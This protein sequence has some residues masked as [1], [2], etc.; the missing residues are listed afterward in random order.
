MRLCDWLFRAILRDCQVL[1]YAVA[2]F[3]L[4]PIERRIYEVARATCEEDGLDLD[5]TTFR[6]QIGY[7]NPLANFKAALR[8]IVATNT[9]PDY[10][11]EL[12]EMTGGGPADVEP[13]ATAKRGRKASHGRVVITRRLPEPAPDQAACRRWRSPQH[14][15]PATPNHLPNR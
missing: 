1:D 3:Q 11:L 8:Q 7:Q 14:P 9:I 6:L 2:Y 4:G 13:E 10:H 5:L 12:V 15:N